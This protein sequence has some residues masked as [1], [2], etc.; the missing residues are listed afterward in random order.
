MLPVAFTYLGLFANIFGST[1]GNYYFAQFVENRNDV[2]VTLEGCYQF[3]RLYSQC[4]SY[5]FYEEPGL[6]GATRCDLY[7]ATVPYVLDSLDP[8][9]NGVWYDLNCGDPL[10]RLPRARRAAS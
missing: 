2:P 9:A 7:G 8:N 4:Y 3:C 10:S 5:H 6:E 1:Q